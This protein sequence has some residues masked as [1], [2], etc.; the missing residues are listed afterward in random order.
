MYSQSYE[1]MKLMFRRARIDPGAFVD[2]LYSVQN[3]AVAGI[4]PG[5]DH[6]IGAYGLSELHLFLER[7]QLRGPGRIGVFRCRGIGR[8]RTHH[9]VFSYEHEIFSHLFHHGTAWH[10]GLRRSVMVV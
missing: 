10:Y 3:D 4:D 8:L 7:A 9:R 6:D 2:R 1:E 5:F